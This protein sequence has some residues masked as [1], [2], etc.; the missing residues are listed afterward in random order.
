M[1][2]RRQG[3]YTFPFHKLHFPHLVAAQ[4]TESNNTRVA[5]QFRIVIYSCASFL[6]RQKTSMTYS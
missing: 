4:Y 2:E 5:K 6:S 1:R 3:I